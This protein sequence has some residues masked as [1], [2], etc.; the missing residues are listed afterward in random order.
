MARYI[1]L[2]FV[3][4]FASGCWDRAVEDAAQ[5]TVLIDEQVAVWVTDCMDAATGWEEWD[6]CAAVGGK[7]GRLREVTLSLDV[8]NGRKARKAAA[9]QWFT[10]VQTLPDVPAVVVAKRSKW[11]R[12]C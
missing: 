9:C 11:R 3:L 5:A 1:Y 8:T 2:L 4:C 7:V 6:E 10:I 12:K